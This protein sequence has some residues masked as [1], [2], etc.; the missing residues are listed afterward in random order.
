M[1]FVTYDA[2]QGVELLAPYSLV[3]SSFLTR[4]SHDTFS[5]YTIHAEQDKYRLLLLKIVRIGTKLL[6]AYISSTREN[7]ERNYEI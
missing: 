7:P 2:I 4:K 6:H 3:R 5:L 1:T